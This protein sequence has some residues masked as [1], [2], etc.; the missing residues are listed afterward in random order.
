MSSAYPQ[1]AL[2]PQ[3]LVVLLPLSLQEGPAPSYAT[4]ND[5]TVWVPYPVANG[6]QYPR[7]MKSSEASTR[8]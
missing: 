2:R 6:A 4:R 8:K 5:H 1:V 7:N 3:D